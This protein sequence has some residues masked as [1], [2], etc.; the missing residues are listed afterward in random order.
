MKSVHSGGHDRKGHRRLE[1]DGQ[2]MDFS[3]FSYQQTVRLAGKKASEDGTVPLRGPAERLVEVTFVPPAPDKIECLRCNGRTVPYADVVDL[4]SVAPPF[5]GDTLELV[6]RGD[7]LRSVP[8]QAWV[9]YWD[10]YECPDQSTHSGESADVK[11]ENFVPMEGRHEM[12]RYKLFG[13]E[14]PDVQV[15]V[16]M[17]N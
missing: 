17:T 14:C 6:F 7:Y 11:E 1:R 8:C 3:C 2:E 10:D 16:I 5:R 9:R 4:R 13:V 12:S 15:K